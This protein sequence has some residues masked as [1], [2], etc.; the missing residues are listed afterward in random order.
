MNE[1]ELLEREQALRQELERYRAEANVRIGYLMG[2]IDLLHEL[3]VLGQR[4]AEQTNA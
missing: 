2:Q 4:Q 3:R 1:Q